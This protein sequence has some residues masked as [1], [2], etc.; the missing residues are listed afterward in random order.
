MQIKIF[1]TLVVS[2]VPYSLKNEGF[3]FYVIL[4]ENLLPSIRFWQ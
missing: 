4:I 3:C 2:V 1:V